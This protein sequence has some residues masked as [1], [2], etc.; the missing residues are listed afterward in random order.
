MATGVSYDLD[1][2]SSIYKAN[3]E[4][5]T[6]LSEETLI[7]TSGPRFEE[8]INSFISGNSS[9]QS[10]KLIEE[11]SHLANIDWLFL[12]SI[13]ISFY[14][15]F[16]HHLF[17]LSKI[18]EERSK[19]KVKIENISGEG[20]NQYMNYL[21]LIGG[22]KSADKGKVECQI[23]QKFRKLRNI[24][25]HKGNMLN[26][27]HSKDVTLHE[28]FDFLISNDVKVAGVLG[29]VRIKSVTILN[30][31][32]KSTFSISDNIVKEIILKYPNA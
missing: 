27:D 10:A 3:L 2:T 21:H 24:L 18:V 13:F 23:I 5:L 1:L 14:S 22:I 29:H 17:A 20:I 4:S 15:Y 28:L 9:E 11:G 8:Y 26:P 32:T 12:N 16:E 19:S 7:A 31:F 25:V 6:R 30:S